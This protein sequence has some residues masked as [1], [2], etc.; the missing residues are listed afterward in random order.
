MVAARERQPHTT[1]NI[2]P[3]RKLCHPPRKVF[4]NSSLRRPKHVWIVK[5]RNCRRPMDGRS[6]QCATQQLTKRHI[7]KLDFYI[8]VCLLK[9]SYGIVQ[10]LHLV[11]HA[12]IVKDLDNR[13][14]C[15]CVPKR[16]DKQKASQNACPRLLHNSFNYANISHIFFLS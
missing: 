12:E 4:Q 5:C 10:S 7:G 14:L 9:W 1:V 16:D 11:L 15:L 3:K 6:L 8:W 13:R 2:V